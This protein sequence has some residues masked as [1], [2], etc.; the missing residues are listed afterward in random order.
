MHV[1]LQTLL[2][3]YIFGGITFIPLAILCVAAFI[4][5][6][7]PI[8]TSHTLNEITAIDDHALETPGIPATPGEEVK[9][10]DELEGVDAHKVGW[11]QVSREYDR[12][13]GLIGPDKIP[14]NHRGKYMDKMRS[15]LD[16]QDS[17]GP[18]NGGFLK[19]KAQ[20]FY[21]VLK[22]GTII[23]FRD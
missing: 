8:K 22:H 23:Y 12:S 21:A 11:L 14:G 20:M 2:V 1:S 17:S 3:V 5:Y 4:Y 15:L 19:I 6:T 13:I 7:S 10:D 9:D 18:N 16:R